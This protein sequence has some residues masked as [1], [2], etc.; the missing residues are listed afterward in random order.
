MVNHD[1]CRAIKDI[2]PDQEVFVD[3]GPEYAAELGID[4]ST[5][6]TYTRPE[7]HKTVEG[8]YGRL[9]A[10]RDTYVVAKE[11]SIKFGQGEYRKVLRIL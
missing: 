5:F 6:D 11:K 10:T 8:I 7:N 4:P 9:H 3:Y 1:H 2:L